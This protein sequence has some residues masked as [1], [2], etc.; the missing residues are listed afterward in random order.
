LGRTGKL[1]DFHH[2]AGVKPDLVTIAKSLS[3][4][5][6]P[7]SAVL[8]DNEVMG[9]IKPGEHGSTY[10][11]NPLA[12]A[13]AKKSVEVIVEEK[14]PENS[15]KMGKLL[16]DGLRSI[17]SPHVKE[18][19]NRGL[20]GAFELVESDK[21]TG[22]DF[23][24]RLMKKGLIT[25]VTKKKNIRIIPPLVINDSQVNQAIEIFKDVVKSY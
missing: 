3:G 15:A 17:K 24:A 20:L 5:F 1:F 11:G 6:M 23:V 2:E 25:N 22:K 14:L 8:A 13:V 12:C 7:V 4:G 10:G 21:V 18:V 16:F 19:R 9:V